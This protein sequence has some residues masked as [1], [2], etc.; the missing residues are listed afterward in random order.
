MEVVTPIQ[1]TPTPRSFPSIDYS[2]GGIWRLQAAPQVVFSSN[3]AYD[4]DLFL[5]Q[6]QRDAYL[7]L[8]RWMGLGVEYDVTWFAPTTNSTQIR[9]TVFTRPN[10]RAPWE[11]WD[12][13][14]RLLTTAET[15]AN[16]RDTLSLTLYFEER[17]TLEVRAEVGFS[18]YL[19]GGEIVNRVEINE[20]TVTTL[21]PPDEEFDPEALRPPFEDANA[22]LPLLDW[23]DFGNG[24]CG[25]R[26]SLAMFQAACERLEA[27]D[28]AGLISELET[29]L[30]DQPDHH[31]V[32]YGQL[33][34][35]QLFSNDLSASETAF[36]RAAQAYI[37]SDQVWQATIHLHNWLSVGLMN[38]SPSADEALFYLIEFREQ[39]YDE[40]GIQLTQANLGLIYEESWRIEPA[41]DYF[42]EWD[43]PQA[44]IVDI[45][46]E[47]LDE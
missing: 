20:F 16:Q 5:Q 43:L 38:G 21:T 45:W 31:G 34:F 3:N 26:E 37:Q 29:L 19:P 46:L 39:F 24:P 41:R 17:V 27:D 23:R 2:L 12:T 11:R 33:G 22:D 30:T 40:P 8:Y 44:E 7:L 42:A 14:E 18:V 1:P 25:W 32:I 10:D 15:P 28:I 47:R 36:E 9:L 6:D 4:A 35:F 13:T